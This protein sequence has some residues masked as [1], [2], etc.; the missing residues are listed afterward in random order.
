MFYDSCF[1]VHLFSV[2]LTR[3]I[4]VVG[5]SRESLERVCEDG[6]F[7]VAIKDMKPYDDVG[8]IFGR[9]GAES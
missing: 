8:T 2:E 6:T 5:V 9:E 3:V 7:L 1:K 4:E